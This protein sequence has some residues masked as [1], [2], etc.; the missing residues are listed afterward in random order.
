MKYTN[1]NRVQRMPNIKDH[2]QQPQSTFE[3]KCKAFRE[4]L[5]PA[6]PEAEKPDWESYIENEKWEWPKLSQAELKHAC[7]SKIQSKSPGPDGITQDMI[8]HAYEAI[9]DVFYLVFSKLLNT[10]YHPLI[11]RQATGAVL[12]KP[13]K[14]D[15]TVPKAYRI[16]TLLNCLGKISEKIMAQ[17]FSYLAETTDLLHESQIGGRLK[18]SAIDAA[19]LLKHEVESNKTP[20]LKTS[21]LFVDVKG[22]YDHVV[23][24]RL[25]KILQTLG[26][27]LCLISW[28]FA[29]LSLRRLRIA[30][31]GQTQQ[32][33][34]ITSGI[35]QG[36]PISPILFLIY[37]RNLFSNSTVLWISYVDDITMTI[38][39]NSLQ[40]NIKILHREAE[41][42]I[43][44]AQSNHIAFDLEKTELM[45]WERSRDA[46]TATLTLPN[47]DIV[48]PSPMIKWLGIHFDANLNFKH[49][50]A[51]KIAKAR[52][53]FFR[54]SRLA[55][56]E[57]GLTPFALRQLY[58][59]CVTSIADYGALVWWKW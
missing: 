46:K 41:K 14:P 3:G 13:N 42:L 24:F 47:G 54:V 6:P 43:N 22:A 12:P 5:F 50:V 2:L 28:V 58:I 30:F 39:T 4:A 27:P 49:H 45:H 48:E 23:K 31:D 16:I 51:I 15:Y 19:L 1:G 33:L 59:A 11:W 52:N 40:N 7:S 21:T 8:T 55:S 56:I 20:K 9:P 57:R 37:R 26:L 38:A 32:F 18:K 29:F 17:R 25:L 35:P 44:L 10:R 36:S 34:P 53:A